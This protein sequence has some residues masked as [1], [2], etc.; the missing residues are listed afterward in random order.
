M[1][2]ESLRWNYKQ[3]QSAIILGYFH[4]PDYHTRIYTFEPGMLYDMGFNNYYGRGIRYALYLHTNIGKS[5]TLTT[6]IGTT[7]YFDRAQISSSYQQINHSSK[8]DMEMQIRWR[9]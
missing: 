3:L 5:V 1:V 4:T 9:F 6:K 7:D 2:S 8:T